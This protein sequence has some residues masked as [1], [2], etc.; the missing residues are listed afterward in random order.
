MAASDPYSGFNYN[1]SGFSNSAFNPGSS[2]FPGYSF[3][4]TANWKLPADI[5]KGVDPNY[6]PFWKPGAGLSNDDPYGL[7]KD[8]DKDKD[9]FSWKDAVRF[10]GQGL[11]EWSKGRYGQGGSSGGGDLKAGGGGGVSQSGDL[12]IVYPQ[13]SQVVPAQGGGLGGKIGALA[14]AALMAPFTGGMS[15]NAA[16]GAIGGA[17]SLGGTVG[18]LFG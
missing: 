10:A 8:K 16:M 1:Q 17:A 6:S 4:D 11:D 5:Y 2:G 12:T 7:N 15:L 3:S 18:S 13:P 14:G 9:K